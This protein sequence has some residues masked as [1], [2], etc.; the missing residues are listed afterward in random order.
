M[1]LY[2]VSF[3]EGEKLAKSSISDTSRSSASLSDTALI[4]QCLRVIPYETVDAALSST[5]RTGR[6]LGKLSDHLVVYLVVFM[7]LF[8]GSSYLHVFDLLQETFV[9]LSGLGTRIPDLS[10]PGIAQARQRLGFS[11]IKD[12][13]GRIAVPRATQDMSSAFFHGYRLM[14]LDG[15]NFDLPD[16][17]NNAEFGRG[18]NQS[19]KGASPMARAMSLIEYATRLVVDVEF[20]PFVGSSEV[21]LA[22]LIAERIQPGM[23]ILADRLF[24]GTDLCRLVMARGSHFVWRAK[25]NL[26]LKPIKFLDDGSFLAH[27]SQDSK[28][29]LTVRV[30]VYTLDGSKEKYRLVTSLLDLG[31]GTANQLARLYPHRWTVETF[32]FEIKEVLR[33]PN[34]ILRSKSPEMVYQELYG[35]FL[36]HYAVRSLMHDAA[37]SAGIPPDHLSFKHAVHV[38]RAHASKIGDFSP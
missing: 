34:I 8:M 19:G 16:T 3:C 4:A 15:S 17:P 7:A 18:S 21:S 14:I 33:A 11:S 2:T 36:A 38:I 30:I 13:F 28:D 23:L 26:A 6:R 25:S 5:D 22:K 24:V 9:W 31:Q 37:H 29:P 27:L 12:L 1:V 35:L 10:E 32:Y 20:G